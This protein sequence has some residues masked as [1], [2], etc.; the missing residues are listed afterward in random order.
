M[1]G[2]N[3]KVDFLSSTISERELNGV[4]LTGWRKIR[5]QKEFKILKFDILDLSPIG[6]R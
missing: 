5:V 4:R 2:K 3:L 6:V 1:R